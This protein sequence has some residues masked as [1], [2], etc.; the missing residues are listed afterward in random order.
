M[1]YIVQ[2]N[3]KVYERNTIKNFLIKKLE[4]NFYRLSIFTDFM[5]ASSS[6]IKSRS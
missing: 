2:F 1:F 6:N 4:T 3:Q 5:M